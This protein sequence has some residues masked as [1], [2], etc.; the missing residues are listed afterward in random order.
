VRQV[1]EAIEKSCGKGQGFYQEMVEGILRP[2]IDPRRLL[3]RAVQCHTENILAGSGGRFTYRRPARRPAIGGLIRP[4]SFRPVPRITVIIDTSG[5]M[6]R[7]DLG[8]AVGL[9]SKV[10]SGLNLRDGV[11]VIV[12]D[13]RVQSDLRVLDAKKIDLRG[14]GGTSMCRLLEHVA[15]QPE[16]DRCEL[17]VLITDGYTDY[18]TERLPFPVVVCLTREHQRGSYYE[19]PAWMDCV[20]INQ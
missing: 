3:M 5:S 16:R 20:N 10:L 7:S 12:G 6:D 18:P 17:A 14:G 1:A 9:V 4:R 11:R 2:R 19:V 8:L 13:T 15:E